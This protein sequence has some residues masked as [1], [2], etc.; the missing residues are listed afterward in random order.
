MLQSVLHPWT[1]PTLTLACPPPAPGNPASGPGFFD[2]RSLE[3]PFH[4]AWFAWIALVLAMVAA[5]YLTSNASL[6]RGFVMKWHL[7]WLLSIFLGSVVPLVVL[8]LSHP[9]AL[10]GSCSTDP[11]A[12]AAALELGQIVPV[13]EIAALWSFVAFPL[14]SVIA[15]TLAGRHPAAGGFFHYRGC[16][17]PRWNPF[18]S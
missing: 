2:P 8:A 15:T 1:P 17:W 18:A 5:C 4:T 11:D 9:T 10:A 12:F 14:L 7:F 3:G 16:P 6:N 13:M